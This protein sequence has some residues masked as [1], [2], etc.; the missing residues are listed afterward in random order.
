MK[1]SMSKNLLNQLK[2]QDKKKHKIESDRQKEIM[3]S[4]L[5][6]MLKGIATNVSDAKSL[7]S[8]AVETMKNTFADKLTE[9][10]KKQ[11]DAPVSDLGIVAKD[12]NKR[13]VKLLEALKDERTG[14]SLA[15]L[16]S[17]NV[18]I[19]VA[20]NKQNSQQMFA[21]LEIKL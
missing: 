19:E 5:L 7:L 20:E 16:N 13:A 1:P 21:D 2:D 17:L 18:L 12:H 11:S 4:K 3:N 10:Q 14:L 6:P 9:I 15:L 8:L